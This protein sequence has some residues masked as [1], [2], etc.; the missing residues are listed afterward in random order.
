[1]D[2]KLKMNAEALADC[3]PASSGKLAF[4]SL[5]LIFFWTKMF[6]EEQS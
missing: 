6:A 3:I 2:Q 4:G 5:F 1:M